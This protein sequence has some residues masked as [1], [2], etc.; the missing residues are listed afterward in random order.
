M[1]DLEGFADD[2]LYIPGNHDPFS[3]FARD[4]NELPILSSNPSGN[5]H[6]GIYKL[7]EDLVII[8]LGGSI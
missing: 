8:G 3:L 2:L 6:R 5:I 4:R 7:H 1:N